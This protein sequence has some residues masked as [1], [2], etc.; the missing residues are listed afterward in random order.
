MKIVAI[1]QARVGS[2]RLPGK[3]LKKVKGKTLLQIHIER[4]LKSRKLNALLVATTY[5]PGASEIIK[6]ATELHVRCYQGSTDDVLDRFYQAAQLEKPD[7]IVRVTSDCPLIDPQL[8]DAVIEETIHSGADY[9]TNTFQEN[10]PDGQDV[11]VFSYRALELTWQKA[12]LTSDRE[13]VTPF[14]RKNTD[15]GGGNMFKAYDFKDGAAY[16]GIRM[17]VDEERDLQV[18]TLLIENLGT[19]KSW[20]DY[21]K[22]ISDHNLASINSTITRNEGYLKSIKKDE[23]SI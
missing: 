22:Y 1:T 13:H 20:M 17:T 23:Q 5:E 10:F 6:T 3:V 21:A 18:A 8:I 12:R 2:T 4:I 16:A 15:I 11:E 9:G 14:I 19:E 7:W